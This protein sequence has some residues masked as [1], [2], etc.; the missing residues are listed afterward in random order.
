MSIIGSLVICPQGHQHGDEQ[1]T[2]RRH[3]R[4]NNETMMNYLRYGKESTT[5]TERHGNDMAPT[6]QRHTNESA[7]NIYCRQRST[8]RQRR[9]N[10]P[11]I[12][13]T[14]TIQQHCQGQQQ[15]LQSNQRLRN[16][17]NS[18]DNHA[19]KRI[20]D[21]TT[22]ATCSTNMHHHIYRFFPIYDVTTN[23]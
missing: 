1:G 21:S 10:T 17:P 8:L 11:H 12:T 7:T 4:S 9:R 5:T 22:N 18:N 15:Q 20:S 13:A 6:R 16:N 3:C 2:R 14:T 19:P 23:Q